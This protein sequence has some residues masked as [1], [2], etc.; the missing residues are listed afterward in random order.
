VAVMVNRPV[1]YPLNDGIGLGSLQRCLYGGVSAG[2]FKLISVRPTSVCL[3]CV[4]YLHTGK[5]SPVGWV[6]Y[7]LSV[8]E[9]TCGTGE[10]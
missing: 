8:V 3:Q 2:F 9:R 1:I 5:G 4:R 10:F 6:H 7:Q